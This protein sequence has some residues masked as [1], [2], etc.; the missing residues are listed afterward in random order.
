MAEGERKHL[1]QRDIR[2]R[3]AAKAVWA[4][5]GTRDAREAMIGAGAG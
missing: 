1:E 2:G 3:W 5:A 4:S